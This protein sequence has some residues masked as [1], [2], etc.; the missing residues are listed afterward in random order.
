MKRFCELFRILP[1]PSQLIRRYRVTLPSDSMPSDLALEA[2]RVETY[3]NMSTQPPISAFQ[4]TQSRDD[5]ISRRSDSIGR[6]STRSNSTRSS[7]QRGRNSNGRRNNRGGAN[8]ASR[9]VP[10]AVNAPPS[11]VQFLAGILPFKVRALCRFVLTFRRAVESFQVLILVQTDTTS[12]NSIWHKSPRYF[13][14]SMP[15]TSHASSVYPTKRS[16]GKT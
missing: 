4:F 14:H 3:R 6:N 15:S 13:K 16:Y 12:I 10:R 7:N 9:T 8:N 2:P 11:T 1:R 5:A